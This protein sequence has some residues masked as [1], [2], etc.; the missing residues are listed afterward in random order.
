MCDPVNH[1]KLC[2]C[3]AVKE[4]K[5]KT[6]RL[7][8]GSTYRNIVGSFLPPSDETVEFNLGSYLEAKIESDLNNYDVFDFKYKPIGGDTLTIW[9]NNREY[10][11]AMFGGTFVSLPK[12]HFNHER[13]LQN[14]QTYKQKRSAALIEWF[15]TCAS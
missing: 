5:N 13:H 14:R 12:N 11:F 6:W 1:I 9:L 8:T 7:V 15:Q 10:H 2:T 4:K 3:A